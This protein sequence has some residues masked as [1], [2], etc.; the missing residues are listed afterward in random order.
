MY[1]QTQ[2]YTPTYVYTDT[3]KHMYTPTHVYLHIFKRVSGTQ[4]S[5]IDTSV[6]NGTPAANKHVHIYIH[7]HMCTRTHVYTPASNEYVY[8]YIHTHMCTRIYVYI[9][10]HSS[11]SARFE[12]RLAKT[13]H[14]LA[15][16]LLSTRLEDKSLLCLNTLDLYM[17]IYECTYIYLCIYKHIHMYRY[18]CIRMC[19]YT[20]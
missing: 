16:S 7:T 20:Y 12:V 5:S 14:P 17:Y 19:I 1:V 11:R 3:F 9:Y 8:I 4:L 13:H 2:T 10:T 6:N 18:V 15:P